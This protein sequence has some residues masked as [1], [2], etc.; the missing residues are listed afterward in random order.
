MLGRGTAPHNRNASGTAHFVRSELYGVERSG[1]VGC[2]L[3]FEGFS[4]EERICW[5]HVENV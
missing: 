5:G 2:Q 4:K 3:N 1:I